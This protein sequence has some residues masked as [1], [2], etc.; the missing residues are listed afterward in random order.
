MLC[1][2]CGAPDPAIH[3]DHT[4]PTL[5]GSQLD[6]MKKVA[7]VAA[8]VVQDHLSYACLWGRG[9]FPHAL[10]AGIDRSALPEQKLTAAN[11]SRVAGRLPN[12]HPGRSGG[13]LFWAA[14]L[15][16]RAGAGAAVMQLARQPVTEQT[17]RF[18]VAIAG[19]L[20]A[21]APGRQT[22]PRADLTMCAAALNA[23][24]APTARFRPDAI[25]AASVLGQF[26]GAVTS[27]QFPGAITTKVLGGSNADCWGRYDAASA[28]VEVRAERIPARTSL[29]D[30]VEK[31]PPC[32]VRLHRQR[33]G[34]CGSSLYPQVVTA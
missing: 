12:V 18:L 32:L 4:C 9:L 16:P 28:Q 31:Q 8:S 20:G 23:A 10:L 14:R 27:K 13:P 33:F 17:C 26:S 29:A 30:S 21:S 11:F 7:G 25:C 19:L 34:G 3:R 2:R 15:A 6:I 1:A 24:G 5:K 22:V